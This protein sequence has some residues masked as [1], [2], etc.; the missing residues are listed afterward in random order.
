MK[1]N[2]RKKIFIRR[3]CLIYISFIL[4]ALSTPVWASG[5][6][7]TSGLT[8]SE[9][10]TIIRIQARYKRVSDDPTSLNRDTWTLSVPTTIVYGFTQDFAG[11][12]TIPY[13][14]RKQRTS[15]GSDRI[16][17]KTF[18]LGDI[19]L[20]GKYRVYR[21]NLPGG[22]S[23]LS[24]L[25]GIELPTGRS[26]DSDAEGKVPRNL[27]VGSG[28]W[29]PIVGVAYSTVSLEDEWDFNLTYQ[30]NT[31]AHNFE[32]GDTLKYNIA[33]LR[34]IWPKELPE[35]GVYT[36]LF[37]VLELNGVWN[38]RNRDESGS[39][40]ASGGNTIFL[41]PGFQMITK[42]YIAETSI[43]IPV[44]Q[45]LNGTQVE[46]DYVIVASLRFTY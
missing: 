13:I 8:P 26:G 24:L 39:V 28:S 25:G 4:C 35:E 42:H 2:S 32:F 44:L 43:Q 14:Y 38:Q 33:Y 15:S 3:S 30:F 18:G 40:T 22:T 12:V 11:I 17:R 45:K 16:T 6:N 7:S 41:S 5:I 21:K 31:E 27:Q 10:Q 1:L 9:E 23:G 37:A 19:T 29:D 34:R 20:L 46:T 36:P